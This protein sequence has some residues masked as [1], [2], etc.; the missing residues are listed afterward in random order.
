MEATVRADEQQFRREQA[1]NDC[2]KCSY[3]ILN[4]ISKRIYWQTQGRALGGQLVLFA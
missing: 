3:S 1:G 2:Q 4:L